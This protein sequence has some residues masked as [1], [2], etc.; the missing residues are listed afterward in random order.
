MLIECGDGSGL[1]Q[2]WYDA[3]MK[4]AYTCVPL[5]GCFPPCEAADHYIQSVNGF[6]V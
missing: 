1:S 6:V 3:V 4:M 5:T 2:L